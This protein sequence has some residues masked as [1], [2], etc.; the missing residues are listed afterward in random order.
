M[1]FRRRTPQTFAERV[2]TWVWPRTS[3]SRSMRYFLLRLERLKASPHQVALGCAAGVFAAVTPLL[4]TQMI[5]A[6][7]IAFGIRAS[8]PA[9]LIGTFFGNPVSWP[10]IWGGTYFAG[11][12]ILGVDSIL[13][14]VGLDAY[15]A[16][17]KIAV[18]SASPEML[19]AAVN[20]LWPV[21]K[22]MLVGSIPLGLASAV[23]I[24]YSLRPI[25]SAYQRSRSQRRLAPVP[26]Y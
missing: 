13:A 4:G 12:H 15:F 9:A 24:Y 14:T 21:F 10:L 20:V 3:W 2:R 7:V 18:M 11:C 26:S 8:I 23:V 16:P 25:V 1:L 17:L 5:L 19:T 22:P 6:A